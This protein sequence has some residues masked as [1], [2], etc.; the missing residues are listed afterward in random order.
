MKMKQY[1]RG[2]ATGIVI[3]VAVMSLFQGK[4][5][6]LSDEEIRERAA[7]MGMVMV[8]AGSGT[9]ADGQHLSSGETE[10]PKESSAI[11]ESTGI[12]E[13]QQPDGGTEPAETSESRQPDGGT[14]LA[15][16]SEGR[17][18][19]EGTEPVET[20]ESQKSDEGTEPDETSE[21]RQPDESIEPAGSSQ[22]GVEG[23]EE[24][25][26]VTK[27]VVITIYSGDGSYTVAEYLK[28]AGLV[29]DAEEYDDYLCDNG[30]ANA[31]RVGQIQ[32][33]AGS[34][35]E[36]IAKLLTMRP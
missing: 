31:I 6:S 14:E 20:S 27:T 21:S 5:E 17:Q 16:T 25:G 3:A 28:R 1:L 33:P 4:K 24:N 2:L 22:S 29:D 13:S 8:M 10:E 35:Y 19:D 9:L 23:N 26:N 11:Q 7:E 30:Y 32:I 36:E 15:E 18:P 34:S 12:S